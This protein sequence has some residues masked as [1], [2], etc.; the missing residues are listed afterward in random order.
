MIPVDKYLAILYQILVEL[1]PEANLL[2]PIKPETM[3][4]L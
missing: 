3:Y 4:I 1:P 2:V